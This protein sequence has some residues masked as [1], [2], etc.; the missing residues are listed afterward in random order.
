MYIF[1][2]FVFFLVNVKHVIIFLVLTL[3]LIEFIKC[4]DGIRLQRLNYYFGLP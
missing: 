2:I 3:A 1:N 4:F